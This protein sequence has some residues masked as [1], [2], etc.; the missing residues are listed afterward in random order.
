MATLVEYD[1]DT[2]FA[3]EEVLTMPTPKRPA[4]VAEYL[5]MPEGAPFF[6][7]IDGEVVPMPSPTLL[8]QK[9][10]RNLTTDFQNYIRKYKLGELYPAPVDVYF[11]EDDYFQPDIVFVAN[12]RFHILTPKNIQGAPDLVVEVLSPSTGYYDLSHKK[13]VYEQEGVREYWLVYPSELRVEVLQNTDNGFVLLNQ[14]R[15]QGVERSA[16]LEGFSLDITEIF[17]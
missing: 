12:E 14:A 3:D 4:T 8:H 7:F 15:K 9:V 5:A 6:Q 2:A 11:S 1:T 17:E 16:V 13:A 10:I